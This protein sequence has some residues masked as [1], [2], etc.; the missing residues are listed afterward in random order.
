[1]QQVFSLEI[2]VFLTLLIC[3]SPLLIANEN[4]AQIY[5]DNESKHLRE[6]AKYRFEFNNDVFFQSDNQFS[7]GWSFQVHSPVAKSWQKIEGPA[8]FL[9]Q[10]GTW[11]PSLTSNG[12]NY[13]LSVSVGQVIQTPEDLSNPDLITNDVPYAGI[14][15]AKT[16]WIAFNDL[17]FRGFELVAG[18]L[19]R[20]SLA[21]QT[22]NFVH[23]FTGSEIANGWDNQLKTEPVFNVNYMRKSKFLQTGTPAKFSFDATL[24]GDLQ[25]GTLFTSTGLRIETRFGINMPYGFGYRA[26]PI[27][28]YLTYDATLAPPRTKDA[29]FYGTFSFGGS[30]FA[31]NLS[32]D[33]NVF[34]DAIHSVEKENL[35][36]IATLGIHYERATW[37]VHFDLNFTSDTIDTSSVTA[38]PN[39]ENNFSTLMI[40][41]RI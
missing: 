9:K 40:E 34:K 4:N 24:S 13:R 10:F 25:L 3:Y 36:G 19:G 6:A 28:R 11:L 12:L 21:E 39:P 30:F 7:N 38:N 33:G 37:A 14:I 29:S 22:Q 31:H 27:G 35:V 23:V 5:P 8:N 18:I 26:D 17:E 41:W 32:L 1:M 16:T 2:S 20:P 15:T